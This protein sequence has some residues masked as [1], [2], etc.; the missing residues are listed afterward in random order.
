MAKRLRLID[1][2]RRI[3]FEQLSDE[4]LLAILLTCVG[5]ESECRATVSVLLEDFGGLCELWRLAH[6]GLYGLSPLSDR[7]AARL[8][9][10][11]EIG[12]RCLERKQPVRAKVKCSADVFNLLGPR[13]R[14]I[15]NE[16]VWILALDGHNGLIARKRVAEGGQH[17]CAI[18]AR[19]VL[20]AA[21]SLGASAFILAHNHPDGQVSPSREDLHLTQK[22][23]AAAACI[24]IPLLDH[25]IIAG[26]QHLSM[27]NAALLRD[28]DTHDR[29]LSFDSDQGVHA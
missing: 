19:D 15:G 27:L 13:L 18:Q 5:D 23:S 9:A 11:F 4:D 8:A 10:A 16:Q 17:G 14:A 6:D 29:Q 1:K 12:L 7:R 22:L 28:R 2:G 3:G 25:V 24:G 26:S 20:R 21:V